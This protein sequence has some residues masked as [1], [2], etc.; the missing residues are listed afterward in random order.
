M[1]KKVQP[2]IILLYFV[3]S[4]F[5]F[6]YSK[7]APKVYKDRLISFEEYCESNGPG[8]LPHATSLSALGIVGCIVTVL[9]PKQRSARK[10]NQCYRKRG[11]ASYL[12]V[13]YAR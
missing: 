10:K 6:N 1:K 3:R 7:L 9:V 12:C 4:S 5:F 13:R 2:S 8:S 11:S